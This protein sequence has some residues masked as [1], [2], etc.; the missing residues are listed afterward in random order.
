MHTKNIGTGR[1]GVQCERLKR[2]YFELGTRVNSHRWLIKFLVENCWKLLGN[3]VFFLFLK[4]SRKKTKAR[5]TPR[6][7]AR[8]TIR[9]T[10]PKKTSRQTASQ[11]NSRIDN[12][13]AHT[14]TISLLKNTQ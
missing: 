12:Q 2:I 11:K 8:R 10:C 5:N 1:D 9:I 6:K 14:T 13:C 4:H 7:K 3:A